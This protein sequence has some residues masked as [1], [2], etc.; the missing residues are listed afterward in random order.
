MVRSIPLVMSYDEENYPSLTL[1]LIRKLTGSDHIIINYNALGVESISLNNIIIPTDIHGRLF[2][3]YRGDRKSFKYISAVDIYNNN[4]DKT[5]IEGKVVLIG[6]TA[7]G[8]LTL[9]QTPFSSALPD[10]EIHANALD[11]I[12]SANFLSEPIGVDV[13]NIF[14]IF[15]VSFLTVM[16]SRYTRIGRTLFIIIALFL[17]I[18]SINYYILFFEG[19]IFDIFLPFFTIIIATIIT[20]FVNYY[21]VHKE[22]SGVK[23]KLA[24]K[25]A[26]DMKDNLTTKSLGK[27]RHAM[28]RDITVMFSDVRGFTNISEA[29]PNAET[30]IDFM[31]DYMTPMTEI[32]MKNHGTVDKYIGDAIMAYWN[33][34]TL[35]VNH[36][37]HAVIATMEQLHALD[38]LNEDIKNNPKYESIMN[39]SLKMGIPII[40]VGIGINTGSAVAG[41]M[42]SSIRSDYT[43]IGDSVNLGARLESLCKYYNSKC[44]ISNFTKERLTGDYIYRYLDLVTVKGKSEPVEIW[45]IHDFNRDENLHKLYD[46][47]KRELVNELSLYHEAIDLYKGEMFGV[48]LKIFKSLTK[49]K[50]K[51]NAKIYDI[52]IQRCEVYIKC[53]PLDF[54]GIFKH[55]TK[56]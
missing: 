45:Q 54:N 35:L 9:R 48:A 51:T 14:I 2:I 33:A 42:G 15:L 13:I 28:Q 16:I 17:M 1:E 44:N 5:E 19:I 21:Y 22:G 11:T 26:L 49:R 29:I 40:D 31:N 46:C 43:V 30:L 53:A 47:T 12:I 38:K 36:A 6:T 18:G 4:Y 3:N 7:R 25:I 27:N 8:L 32:I 20:I 37:E 55:T 24:Q 41:E 10:V 39:M 50:N 56:E 23:N 52:Y 34:P